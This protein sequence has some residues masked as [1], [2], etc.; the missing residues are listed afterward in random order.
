MRSSSIWKSETLCARSSSAAGSSGIAGPSL[1]GARATSAARGTILSGRLDEAVDHLL[2]P[3]LVEGDVELGPF[4]RLD[5]AV[6]ELLVEDALADGEAA[7][8][9]DRPGLKHLGPAL[10]QLRGVEP[11]AA[12]PAGRAP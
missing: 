2:A 6:A 5:P 12:E 3:G 9:A 10:D 1:A 11:P 8:P 7:G 4:N